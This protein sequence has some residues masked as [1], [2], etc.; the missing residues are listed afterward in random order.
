MEARNSW[1]SIE[2][3]FRTVAIPLF[4]ADSTCAVSL[5]RQHKT[6]FTELVFRFHGQD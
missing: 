6:P 4:H 3:S 2:K 1:H 5:G